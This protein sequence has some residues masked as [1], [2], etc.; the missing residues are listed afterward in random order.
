MKKYSKGKKTFGVGTNDLTC[1]V[2]DND[3]KMIPSFRAWHGM[4]GR[5][6]G[7]G[8]QSRHASYSDCTVCDEWK[9]FSVFE[10]WFL[11]HYVDGWHLD[12]DILVKGNKEYAPDKCCYVPQE[13]N[14]LFCKSDSIRGEYPIGVRFHKGK[15]EANLSMGSKTTYL[16]SFTNIGDA[17]ERYKEEKE[18]YIKSLAEKYKDQLDERVY[19]ALCDYKVEITD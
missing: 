5:C 19:K 13:I 14:K 2:F 15:F 18:K 16:G 6:Y 3:G 17:F 10:E 12:K 9:T 11:G 1:K 4:L 7:R 8:Y